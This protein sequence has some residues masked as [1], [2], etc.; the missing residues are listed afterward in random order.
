MS[1]HRSN[2][3]SVLL[4]V[5]LFAA[6]EGTGPPETFVSV[7]D[8][9]GIRIV[10]TSADT[11]LEAP[12]ELA[13][14]PEWVVGELEGDPAYLLSHVAGAMQLPTG[15]VVIANRGTNEVRFYGPDGSLERTRG[16][17]GQGPGEFQYLR[18]LGR[19]HPQGF[20]AFDLNWQ[21]NVYANDGAFLEKTTLRTP[22]G[23][24]PYE[25]ACD[26]HGHI[27]MIGWGRDATEGP[28]EGFY[29]AHDE[30]LL[31]TPDGRIEAELGRRLASERIGSRHGSRPHPAGRATVFA[32]HEDR[33]FVG[34]G[35]RFEVE[36]R[37]LDGS[38]QGRLRGPR[39]PLAVT[40]SVKER[41]LQALLT[42]ASAERHA[43]IRND[44]A[45][46]EWP[47]SLPAYT[48][49]QVDSEGI[50][51]LR[52]FSADPSSPELWSL[53]DPENGYLGDLSLQPR[54]ELLEAGHDYILVVTRNELDVERV[55]KYELL[56]GP[57][58]GQ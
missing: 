31:T 6:C 11:R 37:G 48:A 52:A 21:M 15:E 1:L 56:R 45:E 36:I 4:G 14:Q 19:C 58:A 28:T 3:P 29:Q 25:V 8:S 7:R 51:W 2:I 41:V 35:E 53:M 10:E 57:V 44:F 42:D 33:V 16:G 55:E 43:D 17:E 18:A 9:A 46:W 39:I 22:V 20:V 26:P 49:L 13:E 32:L 34:S 24:T 27:L 5:I 23:V 30:V 47:V 12:W 54:Q 50:V 38:L 40:D